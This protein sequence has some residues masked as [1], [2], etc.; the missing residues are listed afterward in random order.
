MGF[1][2]VNVHVSGPK[3][4]YTSTYKTY[5]LRGNMDFASQ[6]T[7]PNRK[8]VIKYDFDLGGATITVPEKCMIQ[9]E[10]GSLSNGKLKISDTSFTGTEKQVFKDITIDGVVDLPVEAFGVIPNNS[11]YAHINSD[12]FN[13]IKIGNSSHLRFLEGTYYFDARYPVTLTGNYDITGVGM[14][15]RQG[16]H[17][18]IIN[19][20]LLTEPT[21]MFTFIS[22]RLSMTNI[23]ISANSALSTEQ[24]KNIG[25]VAILDPTGTNMEGNIDSAI[26]RCFFF[27]LGCPIY[28][29]GRGLKITNCYFQ[30]VGPSLLKQTQTTAAQ[31]YEGDFHNQLPPYDGRDAWIEGNRFHV[32][33]AG[34]NNFYNHYTEEQRLINSA[35]FAAFVFLRNP[36]VT[37]TVGGVTYESSFHQVVI[38]NN[39]C[40]SSAVQ[41]LMM[42]P[43]KGLL[44]EG[45]A[46]VRTSND[47]TVGILRLYRDAEQVVV[48][49]NIITNFDDKPGSIVE[50]RGNIS[51]LNICNNSVK[52][53]N[54]VRFLGLDDSRPDGEYSSFYEA[55]FINIVGNNIS[56][57]EDLISVT[58]Y[59]ID[60]L[61]EDKNN[62]DF[63]AGDN[64]RDI[65]YLENRTNSEQ[66]ISHRTITYSSI[67]SMYIL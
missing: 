67:L 4:D 24:I 5:I 1:D 42:S 51:H 50:I 41:F 37:N 18:K 54:L 12:N 35:R 43:V 55:S 40:D 11:A 34:F 20:E 9:F 2:N 7:E 44:F 66:D 62:V 30:E 16:T 23:Q 56:E 31:Q 46:F 19:A 8:Y 13:A 65:V 57:C 22:V 32:I 48:S 26:D 14:T 59:S 3:K 58:N 60:N 17:I 63:I 39:Y 38:R 52:A 53:R 64:T 61:F 27:H 21:F 49:D 25:A 36:Y 47:P 33:Y 15:E 29:R 10:G 45:N 6:V 28:G